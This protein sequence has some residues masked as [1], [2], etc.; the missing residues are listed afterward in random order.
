MKTN[1]E[2][3]NKIHELMFEEYKEITRCREIKRECQKGGRTE[4]ALDM[5]NCEK[6]HSRAYEALAKILIFAS[7]D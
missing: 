1:Q 6:E 4:S 5:L 7:N 3:V 2:I